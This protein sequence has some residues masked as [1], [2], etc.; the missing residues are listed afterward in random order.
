MGNHSSNSDRE[1]T[2]LQIQR[3]QKLQAIA[4]LIGSIGLVAISFPKS[5]III[6]PV[7]IFLIITG[8]WILNLRERIK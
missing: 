8:F 3:I 6:V 4:I 2:D 7:V 5:L 1:K